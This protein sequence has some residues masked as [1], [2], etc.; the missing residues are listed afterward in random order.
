D[1]PLITS[2]TWSGGVAG[3]VSNTYNNDFDSIQELLN[4]ADPLNFTYD[5]DGLIRKQ[6]HLRRHGTRSTAT[7]LPARSAPS[8]TPMAIIRLASWRPF[9][10]SRGQPQHSISN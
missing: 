2:A 3:A 9:T 1:G 7:F 10:S 8:H 5:P 4:G 6:A